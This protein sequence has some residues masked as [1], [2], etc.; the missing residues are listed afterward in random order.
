MHTIENIQ[1]IESTKNIQRS[2]WLDPHGGAN[3][4]RLQDLFYTME[5][6]GPTEFNLH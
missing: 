6:D 5:P 2:D 4:K 3:V 1:L